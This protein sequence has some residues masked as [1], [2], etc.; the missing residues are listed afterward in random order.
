MSE[1][2][3]RTD[4]V[5][6]LIALQEQVL[7]TKAAGRIYSSSHTAEIYNSLVTAVG[8]AHGDGKLR[9]GAPLLNAPCVRGVLLA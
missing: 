2:F 6:T 3:S 7:A 9:G 4:L 5:R 1:E 8:R